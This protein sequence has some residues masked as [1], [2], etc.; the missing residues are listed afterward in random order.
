MDTSDWIR[1]G[2]IVVLAL[3][4]VSLTF[5]LVRKMMSGFTDRV[6]FELGVKTKALEENG[7]K[8]LGDL[9]KEFRKY[10]QVNDIRHRES[11]EAIASLRED[12]RKT[13]EQNSDEHQEIYEFVKKKNANTDGKL[14]TFEKF[15][16]GHVPWKKEEED[17]GVKVEG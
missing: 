16:V 2:E 3:T 1:G 14:E 5:I 12:T 10:V 6:M 17:Y 4:I 7:G 13:A 11:T 8:S 15:L 9:P